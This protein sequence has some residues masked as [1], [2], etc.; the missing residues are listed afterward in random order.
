MLMRDAWHSTWGSH[1]EV[2]MWRL[3][4]RHGS[5]RFSLLSAMTSEWDETLRR[6]LMAKRRGNTV[7][8]GGFHVCGTQAVGLRAPCDYVV[9]GEGEEGM[10]EVLRREEAR[11]PLQARKHGDACTAP[12]IV[13]AAVTADIDQL[14]WPQRVR[15]FLEAYKISDLMWPA[16]SD[17]Q[18]VAMMLASRGCVHDCDFCASRTVWGKGVRLRSADNVVAELEDLKRRFGT[19]TIVFID[20]SLGQAKTWTLELCKV[21]EN[22]RLGMS[23]Y[24]QSNLTISRDV[25]QAMAAAGCTKIGFGLEGISPRSVERFKPHNPHDFDFVNDLFDY[26]NSLGL[27]VKVYLM[28]GSPW[29]TE[30][31]IAEYRRN[32]S[33]IRANEIKISYFTPFPG[34]RAWDQ[35][36]DQLVTQDWA[37]FD[38][39]AMPVVHNPRIS[40]EQY[41]A[42][43]AGLFQTFYGSQT[44]YDVTAQMLRR[45]PHYVQSYREFAD[46][47][48]AFNMISGNES[49]LDLLGLDRESVSLADPAGVVRA[50]SCS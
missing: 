39:V 7:V 11:E 15:R 29:E 47:L 13:K 32:I 21:I 35:Y 40:V 34:T 50:A 3:D 9:L 37:Q 14:P 22:A 18:N 38:T 49:W 17:Q 8:I 36:S 26:C 27:F 46:Y 4:G 44:Y 5:Q 16:P 33:H 24:H 10:R 23:W 19:N 30:R 48:C 45:F 2:E 41:H 43:R 20:Q 28:L 6:A 25:L 1:N 42:I 12:I 31:D